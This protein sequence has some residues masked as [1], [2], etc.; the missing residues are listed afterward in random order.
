MDECRL[1]EMRHGPH[2]EQVM[3]VEEGDFL[4]IPAGVPTSRTTRPPRSRARSSPAPIRTSRSV[5]ALDS[6]PA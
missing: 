3:R 5:V 1:T 2:P 6:P 4:Y